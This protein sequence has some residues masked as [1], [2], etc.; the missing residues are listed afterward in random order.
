MCGCGSDETWSRKQR[1]RR[2]DPVT[3]GTGGRTQR[4]PKP[5]QRPGPYSCIIYRSRVHVSQIANNIA[6]PREEV[7]SPYGFQYSMHAV[8]SYTLHTTLICR[9]AGRSTGLSRVPMHTLILTTEP[10]ANAT[11]WCPGPFSCSRAGRH[12][13]LPPV[14]LYPHEHM[15]HCHWLSS[16]TRAR[17][18]Q[19]ERDLRTEHRALHSS[20]L[21][22][23]QGTPVT[24][25][26]RASPSPA[27][28]L[29]TIHPHSTRR[30]AAS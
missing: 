2:R 13:R 11:P 16:R 7:F 15:P 5:T 21:R 18:R 10:A 8:H 28:C 27:A 12:L 24:A 30:W 1:L 22:P 9:P 6:T 29:D 20:T 23:P 4:R 14:Q 17:H 25:G 19:Q 26:W 3:E